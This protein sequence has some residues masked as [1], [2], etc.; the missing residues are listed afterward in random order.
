MTGHLAVTSVLGP[1]HFGTAYCRSVQLLRRMTHD[2]ILATVNVCSQL[3]QNVPQTFA[4]GHLGDV[5][6][7]TLGTFQEH[8]ANVTVERTKSALK[9]RSI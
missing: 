6:V 2:N 3:T 8:S 4:L 1:G 9:Q 5:F 7:C